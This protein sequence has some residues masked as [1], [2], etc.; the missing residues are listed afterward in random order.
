MSLFVIFLASLAVHAAEVNKNADLS[1][2]DRILASTDEE[3]AALLA[4]EFG[5]A[6]A[7]KQVARLG[8]EAA[9]EKSGEKSQVVEK[10][11]I[12]EAK[13][14]L[15]EAEIPVLTETANKKAPQEVTA[16]P[17]RKMII[18]LGIILSAILGAAYA[19]RRWFINKKTSAPTTQIRIISQHYLGPRKSLAIVYV[20]GESLLVGITDNSINLVKQL[21]LIDDEV[22]TGYP[23][24]FDESLTFAESTQ[25]E[26]GENFS[27]KGLKELVST[28]LKNM[29]EI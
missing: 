29:R 6:N 20:A 21:S 7:E 28:R 12:V 11:Q 8:A 18:S 9:S 23:K 17:L 4:E 15:S 14:N 10:S 1:S 22:P 24:K 3:A 5:P 25:P 27:M 2:E 26:S 13:G 19:A 16:Q